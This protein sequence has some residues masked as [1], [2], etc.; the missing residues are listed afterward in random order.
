MSRTLNIYFSG[1]LF[2][3][4]H[5]AGNAIIAS[6]LSRLSDGRYRVLLPQDHCGE[7][8]EL[9]NRHLAALFSADAV[10]FNF[11][12]SDLSP[13]TAAEFIYAKFLDIPAV[14]LRTD[15]RCAGGDRDGDPWSPMC[16]G[17]PRC[18]K[19]CLNGMKMYQAYNRPE[20]T[21]E[22]VLRL[23]SEYLARQLIMKLDAAVRLPSLFRG[24]NPRAVGI[25]EWAVQSCGNRLEQLLTPAKI[26]EIVENKLV[27][28]LI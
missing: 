20:R 9:R 22:Q 28:G 19:L 1:D 18:S 27:A 11:D 5:L 25:Y 15:F 13:D 8:G 2:D 26:A 24:D 23:F 12:G 3:Y 14:L 17:H 4:K 10:I 6:T 21:V 16:S 7:A